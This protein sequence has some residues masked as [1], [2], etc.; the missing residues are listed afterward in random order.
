MSRF[1]MVG[2]LAVLLLGP[3][4]TA[5]SEADAPRMLFY[6]TQPFAAGREDDARGLLRRMEEHLTANYPEA[7][8]RRTFTTPFATRPTLHSFAR[9][10]SAAARLRFERELREDEGWAALQAE[11]DQAFEQ[12]GAEKVFLF[13]LGGAGRDDP[14]LPYRWLRVAGTPPSKTHAARVL[15]AKL[16]EYLEERY[17]QIDARAYSADLHRPDAVYILI[18]YPDLTTWEQVRAN[19]L[20][21]ERYRE[22]EQRA[23]G[24]FLEQD[25]VQTMLLESWLDSGA[26]ANE[27]YT[28]GVER[29]RRG[30]ERGAIAAYRL[31]LEIEPEMAVA[32]HNLG[33]ALQ[34][35]GDLAGAAEAFRRWIE[36]EPRTAKAR[37]DL[38]K[39]LGELGDADGAV[40]AFRAA[41]ALSPRNAPHQASLGWW[42]FQVGDLEAAANACIEAI[43][44]DPTM[45]R[46]HNNLGVVRNAQGNFEAAAQHYRDAIAADPSW[47]RA[48]QNLA[49]LHLVQGDVEAAV[50]VMREAVQQAPSNA[51]MCNSL[52]WMLV[53]CEQL[54]LRDAAEAVRLAKR[55]TE[56]GGAVG[57]YWG[58]YGG[59]LFRAGRFAEADEALR[60][61]LEYSDRSYPEDGFLL[62]MV[63]HELGNELEAER[64]Y[65][66]AVRWMSELQSGDPVTARLRAE[67]ERTLRADG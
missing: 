1:L 28:L 24:L 62:A 9:F 47:W 22:L 17:P 2:A 36:L 7:L 8:G 12:E 51:S 10:E 14:L 48:Y 66:S 52:A 53:T 11:L 61:A 63:Q 46:A 16:V 41:I 31:A 58:T 33:H 3:S 21:D 64:W 32:V 54:E 55:A 26:G 59:A 18:D 35:T 6:W 34:D 38:G 20:V 29:G 60:L 67:A 43:E 50:K 45:A 4:A 25:V 42:L 13:P 15:A 49:E 27:Y 57:A 37:S 5:Q 30:D 23:E 39:V 19:L 56:L 65:E 40:E 44:I